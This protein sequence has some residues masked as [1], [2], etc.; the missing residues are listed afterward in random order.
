MVALI[1]SIYPILKAISH[2]PPVNNCKKCLKDHYRLMTFLG[3]ISIFS[4]I[5]FSRSGKD[6]DTQ[7]IENLSGSIKPPLLGGPCVIKMRLTPIS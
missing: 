1:F 7:G 4:P 6:V 2:L 3:C 5:S